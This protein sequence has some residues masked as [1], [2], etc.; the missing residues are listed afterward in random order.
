MESYLVKEIGASVAGPK[1][2]T[3][4]LVEGWNFI[5][6]PVDTVTVRT[7]YNPLCD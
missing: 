5:A 1:T 3:H 2:V 4:N 6:F 7:A